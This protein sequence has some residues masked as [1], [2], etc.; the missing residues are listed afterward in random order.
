MNQR[1]AAEKWGVSQSHV[2]KW[3]K[4]GKIPAVK[5]KHPS[6]ADCYIIP[7]DFPCPEYIPRPKRYEDVLA[8]I[9]NEK[10]ITE[11]IPPEQAMKFIWDHQHNVSIR[12]LKRATGLSHR[13][14][15]SLYEQAF[16]D[17]CWPFPGQT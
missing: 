11:Q 9:P 3:M 4:A 5:G 6:G 7:D 10:P 13:E 8:L 16:H 15:M 1:E 17:E 14:V 12:Q 2:S